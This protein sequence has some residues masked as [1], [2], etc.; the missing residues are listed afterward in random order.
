MSE[1]L[2]RYG[3]IGKPLTLYNR[4]KAK[5]DAHNARLG[6]CKVA[7]SIAEAV[8]SSDIIWSC[9]Q[10]EVAVEQTF[11]EI[12]SLSIEGKLFVDSSTISPKAANFIVQRVLDAGGEF[13]ALPG[14]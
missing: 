4:T 1:N 6:H 11:E 8:S 2:L 14:T 13:V 3:N 5:A 10:D 9:L 7:E 12:Y